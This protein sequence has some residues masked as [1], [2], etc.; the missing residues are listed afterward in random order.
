LKP[1]TRILLARFVT[2]VLR[3]STALLSSEHADG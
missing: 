3:G 1:R 2:A